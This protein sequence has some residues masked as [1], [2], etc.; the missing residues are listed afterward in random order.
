M[1]KAGILKG[2]ADGNFAPKS[3]FTRAQVAQVLFTIDHM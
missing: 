2:D 3:P 1:A